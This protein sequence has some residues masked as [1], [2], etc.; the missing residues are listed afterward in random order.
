MAEAVTGAAP[1]FLRSYTPNQNSVEDVTSSEILRG[2][3]RSDGGARREKISILLA[4]SA[5]LYH[6]SGV[7]YIG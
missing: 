7:S 4:T 5:R 2:G 6:R 3:K 1:T